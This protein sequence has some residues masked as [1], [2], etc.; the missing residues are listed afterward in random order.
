MNQSDGVLNSFNNVSDDQSIN[1]PT[2]PQLK[3][4]K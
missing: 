2:P 4:M 3:E 1:K